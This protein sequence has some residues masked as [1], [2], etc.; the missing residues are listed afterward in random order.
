MR[1]HLCLIILSILFAIL[2]P[3]F[4]ISPD[5]IYSTGKMNPISDIDVSSDGGLVAA[6]DGYLY[7]ISSEGV[8]LTRGWIAST[9]DISANGT[10]VVTA[11]DV[12]VCAFSPE[13][14]KE[15]CNDDFGGNPP[16][17]FITKN[18][19]AII[20]ASSTDGRVY[21][22]NG[23]GNLS[24]KK[25]IGNSYFSIAVSEGGSYIVGSLYPDRFFSLS[26]SGSLH[27]LW[28]GVK[29][30]GIPPA[31]TAVTMNGKF[32]V[33]IDFGTTSKLILYDRRGNKLWE[34][35]VEGIKGGM[36]IS[37][38]GD[39]IAHGVKQIPSGGSLY[40]YRMNQT[41]S[42]VDQNWTYSFDSSVTSLAMTIS[43]DFIAV[44]CSD[45]TLYLFDKK[46]GTRLEYDT[47]EYS[48]SSIGISESGTAIAAG[49]SQGKIYLFSQEDGFAIIPTPIAPLSPSIPDV[50]VQNAINVTTPPPLNKSPPV[51]MTGI[52]IVLPIVVLSAMYVISM[53]R[54]G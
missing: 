13:G 21:N 54:R 45:G 33:G 11:S 18:D 29:G 50:P 40:F 1:T 12:N 42:K 27:L 2:C 17:I 28:E 8:L 51:L 49:T 46:G 9:V 35:D 20:T 6:T 25:F 37:R 26:D 19:T 41:T 15:W 43:G 47:G 36:A 38:Y 52:A 39:Y 14:Q 4:A 3:A 16:G 53:R 23:L 44:G 34:E 5:W 48:V 24:W 32:L 31:M 22:F 10:L 30:N 7:L